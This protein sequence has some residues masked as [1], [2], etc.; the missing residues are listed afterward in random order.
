MATLFRT[1][2]FL[3]T[4]LKHFTRHGFERA[5]G[6]S[7]PAHVALMAEPATLARRVCLVTGANQGLVSTPGHARSLSV[8]V[9]VPMNC[10]KKCVCSPSHRPL[11]VTRHSSGP[12]DRDAAGEAV[13]D[14][15]PVL[16][17]RAK[18]QGRRE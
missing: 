18:G 2:A 10:F 8:A 5:I 3:Y 9:I 15:V 4:G 17:K 11:H 7:S 16:Q 12:G 1:P 13:R 6:E 14:R